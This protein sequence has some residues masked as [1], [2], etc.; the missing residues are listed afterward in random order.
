[1]IIS[2]GD[3]EKGTYY[4]LNKELTTV[5]T[6]PLLKVTVFNLEQVYFIIQS[7]GRKLRR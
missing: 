6:K 3:K 7:P 5:E 2:Q 1:M 4:V